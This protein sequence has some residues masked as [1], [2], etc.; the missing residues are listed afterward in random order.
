MRTSSDSTISRVP[1]RPD[2]LGNI[3]S[4]RTPGDTAPTAD[5]TRSAKLVYPRSHFVSQPLAIPGFSRRPHAASVDVRMTECKAGVPS[6][7]SF[8]MVSGHVGDVIDRGAEAGGADHGTVGASQTTL[9]DVVP[10]RVLE[11]F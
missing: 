5:A 3:D 10:P 11:I 7:P 1:Y 9:G 4:H 2:L 6:S 8:G